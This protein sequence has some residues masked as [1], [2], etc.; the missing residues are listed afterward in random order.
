[1]HKYFSLSGKNAC[2]ILRDQL[3]VI[4]FQ[5]RED[6]GK[7]KPLLNLTLNDNHRTST[8]IQ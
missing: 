7:E 5:F 3:S 6:V 2:H 1:M 4:T 8:G